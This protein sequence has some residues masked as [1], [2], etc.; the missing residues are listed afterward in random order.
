MPIVCVSMIGFESSRVSDH[1]FYPRRF[2]LICS[3][4]EI[5]CIWREEKRKEKRTKNLMHLSSVVEFISFKQNCMEYGNY[6]KIQ[7]LNTSTRQNPIK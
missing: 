2:N 5:K 4:Y 1:S 3:H 7:I 6:T